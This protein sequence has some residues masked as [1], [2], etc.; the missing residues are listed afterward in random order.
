ML[1]SDASLFL[2]VSP[3]KRKRDEKNLAEWL[4]EITHN[5]LL[6]LSRLE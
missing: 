3:N 2:I 5:N 6:N 4:N 1:E